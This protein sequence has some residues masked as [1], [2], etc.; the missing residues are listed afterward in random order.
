MVEPPPSE[1]AP[2]LPAEQPAMPASE[3]ASSHDMPKTASNMPLVAL[4]GLLSMAAAFGMR[5]AAKRMG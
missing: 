2:S 4:A 5:L 3:T 1:P